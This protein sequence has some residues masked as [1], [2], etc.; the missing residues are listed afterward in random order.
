MDMARKRQ[1]FYPTLAAAINN[2]TNEAKDLK[3][4]FKFTANHAFDDAQALQLL[5]N[6]VN[7]YNEAF[8]EI[9]KKHNGYEKMVL[10][11]WD[12]EAKATEVKDLFSYA[13]GELHSA[14]IF[15]LNLKIRDINEYNRGNMKGTKRKVFK[16]T[17]MH[18][19]E[20]SVL[21]L[22]RRLQELDNR[23]QVVLSK[24]SI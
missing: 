10:D 2:Y 16:E 21:Q 4:A 17:M 3:D 19:I 1:D 12:S 9:N 7:S 24:L 8:E 15:T 20:G 23:A 6:A 5:T 11:L 14:N 13:L 18:E 22:E